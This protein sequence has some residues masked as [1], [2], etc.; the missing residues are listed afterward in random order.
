MLLLFIAL[1]FSAEPDTHLCSY[2]YDKLDQI[3]RWETLKLESDRIAREENPFAAMEF[4]MDLNRRIR[5]I[6]K[7]I[8]EENQ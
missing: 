1:A 2:W 6:Q 7:K 5:A 4:V 3:E 8:E